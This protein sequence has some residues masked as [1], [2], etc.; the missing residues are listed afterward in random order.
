MPRKII[1]IMSS[2]LFDPFIHSLF[3]RVK[4]SSARSRYCLPVEDSKKSDIWSN[5]DDECIV[6]YHVEDRAD[7]G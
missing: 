2:T 7:Q 1:L 6:L 5:C 4:A 3:H